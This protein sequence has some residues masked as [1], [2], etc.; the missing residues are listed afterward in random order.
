MKKELVHASSIRLTTAE[1][2]RHQSKEARSRLPHEASNQYGEGI[3]ERRCCVRG[4]T[5]I[6]THGIAMH[7]IGEVLIY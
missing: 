3:L 7:A 6:K 1:E 4:S 5:C 2:Y